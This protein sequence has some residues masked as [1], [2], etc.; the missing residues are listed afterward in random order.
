M[1]RGM[2]AGIQHTYHNPRL[3]VSPRPLHSL[4]SDS[5]EGTGSID[6]PRFPALP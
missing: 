6:V 3:I 4:P 5:A 2:T 1:V